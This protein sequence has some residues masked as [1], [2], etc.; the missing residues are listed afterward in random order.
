MELTGE[1]ASL[2]NTAAGPRVMLSDDGSKRQRSRNLDSADSSLISHR[3]TIPAIAD[4][5]A[6]ASGTGK[7]QTGSVPFEV[8]VR[9]GH[10]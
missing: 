3:G 1:L 10:P 5:R 8:K 7:L 9:F 4:G 6:R 2:G